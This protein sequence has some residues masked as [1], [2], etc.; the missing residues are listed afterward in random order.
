[1][2][3]LQLSAGIQLRPESLAILREVG[4]GVTRNEKGTIIA[5]LDGVAQVLCCVLEIEKSHSRDGVDSLVQAIAAVEN[6]YRQ[7][8][9]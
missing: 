6:V 7:T 2:R 5:Y 3:Y 4:V 1:M 9:G 8:V